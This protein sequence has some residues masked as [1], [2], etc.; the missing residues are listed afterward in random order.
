MIKELL[1]ENIANIKKNDSK[2][3]RFDAQNKVI[4][5]GTVCEEFE[6]AYVQSSTAIS[7]YSTKIICQQA[8]GRIDCIPIMVAYQLKDKLKQST[9]KGKYLEITGRLRSHRKT[10][11]NGERKLELY[12]L[13]SRI[14]VFDAKTQEND[15]NKLYLSG[16]V[17]QDVNAWKETGKID[18]SILVYR[19][20]KYQQMDFFPCIV[21][22]N[23]ANYYRY[24][25]QKGKKIG[26]EGTLQS[27]EYP[28][29]AENVEKKMAYEV[30]VKKMIEI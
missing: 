30:R 22:G 17:C 29:Y 28:K 12:V 27:R 5:S 23:L 24:F 1:Q 25:L 15:V 19:K 8:S 16:F 20:R 18:F 10:K 6:F 11:E 3:R 4:L 7:F 21:K 2:G 26:F 9:I 14:E 13:A